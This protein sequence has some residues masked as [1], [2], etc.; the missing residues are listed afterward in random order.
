MRHTQMRTMVRHVY[1]PTSLA[2]LWA[3]CWEAELVPRD[4]GDPHCSVPFFCR[5]ESKMR[6]SLKSKNLINI[7]IL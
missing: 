7:Y 6:R 5:P 1:I 4:P 2:D 3:E